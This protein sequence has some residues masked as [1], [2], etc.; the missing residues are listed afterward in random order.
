M[1][2]HAGTQGIAGASTPAGLVSALDGVD[3]I[4]TLASLYCLCNPIVDLLHQA[5]LLQDRGERVPGTGLGGPD[6]VRDGR[7]EN[8]A[9]DFTGSA[10]GR[11]R[12]RRRSRGVLEVR[13]LE[14]KQSWRERPWPSTRR[15]RWRLFNDIWDIKF[16][17]EALNGNENL[18]LS[19][20]R[21]L[22]IR[23]HLRRLHA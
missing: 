1:V 20:E 8:G 22:E 3:G 18:S 13:N 19:N 23:N 2:I 21:P 5:A 15:E 17:V 16:V 9:P 7:V 4:R 10:E 11:R 6:Y 14:D 12:Q